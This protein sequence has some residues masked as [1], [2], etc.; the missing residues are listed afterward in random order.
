MCTEQLPP[1]GYP[2]AVKYIISYIRNPPFNAAYENNL[3]LFCDPHKI[4]KSLGELDVRGSVHNS[5]IHKEKS[6][7]MQQC[8]KILLFHIYMKLNMF[9]A[10]HRPSSGA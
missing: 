6:N 9:R 10:E 2:I 5:K 1:G 4:Q 8:I 3:C 7:K